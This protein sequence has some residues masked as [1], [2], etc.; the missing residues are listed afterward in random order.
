MLWRAVWLENGACRPVPADWPAARY[1]VDASVPGM[2]GGTGATADWEH[3][4]RVAES[5]QVMLA[6]GL[7]PDNV[8]D[9]IRV[10]APAGVDVSGGVERSPGQ[11]DLVKM[12]R[13]L[14]AVREID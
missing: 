12:A 1:V 10:V 8:A 11:K 4:A 13:F 2:Y 9:A 5:V 7:T 6:G 3:A 14:A